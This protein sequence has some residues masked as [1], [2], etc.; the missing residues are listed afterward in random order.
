LA[1]QMRR[2]GEEG[3]CSKFLALGSQ[4]GKPNEEDWGGGFL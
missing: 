3:F 2:I 4:T 1:S